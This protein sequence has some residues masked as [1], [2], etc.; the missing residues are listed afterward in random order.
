MSLYGSIGG[1]KG[2]DDEKVRAC[3]FVC[4][5]ARVLGCEGVYTCTCRALIIGSCTILCSLYDT[6]R[7]NLTCEDTADPLFFRM[8]CLNVASRQVKKDDVQGKLMT[9][10]HASK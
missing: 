1:L 9:P 4:V 10:P 3:A 7:F 5:R 6:S 8:C 2:A